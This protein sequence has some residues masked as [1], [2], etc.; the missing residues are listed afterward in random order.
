MVGKNDRFV[1]EIVRQLSV[2]ACYVFA[3]DVTPLPIAT[4]VA[5]ELMLD[6]ES[7]ITIRDHGAGSVFDFVENAWGWTEAE[8][9][10]GRCK[11]KI[12]FVRPK[13]AHE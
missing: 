9:A 1:S 8:Y 6:G 11:S 13:I 2:S 7:I 4:S 5:K 12:S 3:L 10:D